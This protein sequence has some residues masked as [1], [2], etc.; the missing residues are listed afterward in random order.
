MTHSFD[1]GNQEI[2][3]SSPLSK[4]SPIKPRVGSSLDPRFI[5][6]PYPG[7]ASERDALLSTIEESH[8]HRSSPNPLALN[9][10]SILLINPPKTLE[11]YNLELCQLPG[12]E[13]SVQNLGC[14]PSRAALPAQI[15]YCLPYFGHFP[16]RPHQ[17]PSLQTCPLAD[18]HFGAPQFVPFHYS[19][20]FRQ[21]LSS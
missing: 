2:F 1:I 5:S 20:F 14:S 15:P 3:S 4:Q 6:N 18:S 19:A 11:S 21:A 12:N 7:I 9:I 10:S 8:Q 16:L 13:E 17:F